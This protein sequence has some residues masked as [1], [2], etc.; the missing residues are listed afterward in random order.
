ML[1]GLIRLKAPMILCM[2]LFLGVRRFAPTARESTAI[3]AVIATVTGIG[4]GDSFDI[5]YGDSGHL[6]P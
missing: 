2:L 3:M 1:V 4:T 5:Q 6:H